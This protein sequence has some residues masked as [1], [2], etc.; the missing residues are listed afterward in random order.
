MPVVVIARITP[1]PHLRHRRNAVV[2]EEA[3]LALAL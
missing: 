2:G 3:T 1:R